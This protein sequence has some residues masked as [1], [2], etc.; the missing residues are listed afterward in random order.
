LRSLYRARSQVCFSLWFDFGGMTASAPIAPTVPTMWPA[1]WP[2]SGAAP[3]LAP[4]SG[5]Q[6]PRAV[7]AAARQDGAHW[8]PLGVREG[9]C[10]RAESA[11]PMARMH[12]RPFRRRAIRPKSRLI[13]SVLTHV[14][15]SATS[16]PAVRCGDRTPDAEAGP[17]GKEHLGPRVRLRC[18]RRIF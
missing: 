18:L 11:L 14:G 8:A 12:L 3:A 2:L 17:A 5:G 15:R 4:S 9:A 6:G 16:P 10:L 7:R 13:M 1:P